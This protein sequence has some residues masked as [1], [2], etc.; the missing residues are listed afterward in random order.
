MK[1]IKDLN[2]KG[3]KVLV[4]CDFNVPL[5]DKG[6]IVDDFRLKQVLPTIRYLVKE[7][8][9][10]ILLSHLGR[11]LRSSEPKTEFTLKPIASKLRELLDKKVRFVNDCV[12]RKSRKEVERMEE[13][14]IVLLENVRFYEGERENSPEFSKKLSELGDAY[15]NE[16][17]GV[18][19]REHASIVGL[20]QYLPSAAGLLLKKEAESLLKILEEP[21]R[22]LVIIIGGAKFSTKLKFMPSFL[23]HADHLLL[24]GLVANVILR[25]KGIS[26]GKTWPEEEVVEKINDV[27]LTDNKLHL[28][29]DVLVSEDKEGKAYLKKSGPG[30]VL[31]SE[32]ILDIGPETIDMFTEVIKEAK[33]IVWNGPMGVFEKDEFKDGTEKIA[34]AIT[35]NKEAFTVAGGGDTSAALLKFDLR[36]KF[37]HV[38]TGG[39]A[40]LRFLSG[41]ELPGIKVLE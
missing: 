15:I 26:V 2:L 31:K 19:H 14:E 13:G 12:G 4:R 22:P 27:I 25:V 36:E 29:V 9:K 33:T 21:A 39:G 38:S 30:S 17:F 1:E 40:M 18:S 16:A 28:P 23:N 10:V 24:G 37:D 41:E 34:K 35:E 3:E 7:R 8:A 6:D 32:V 11:P 5:N 20:P